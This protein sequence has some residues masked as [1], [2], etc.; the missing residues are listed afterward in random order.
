MLC[1]FNQCPANKKWGIVIYK[2]M[3]CENELVF[4]GET[5][6]CQKSLG[7][8]LKDQTNSWM[9]AWQEMIRHIRK[10]MIIN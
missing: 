2:I 3:L 9:L 1:K 8:S 5:N 7:V 4:I 10:L 6:C